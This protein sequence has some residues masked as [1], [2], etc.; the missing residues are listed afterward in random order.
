MEVADTSSLAESYIAYVDRVGPEKA[1]DLGAQSKHDDNNRNNNNNSKHDKKNK[2][3]Q[4]STRRCS[5]PVL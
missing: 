1:F 5:V 4:E 3:I 2:T